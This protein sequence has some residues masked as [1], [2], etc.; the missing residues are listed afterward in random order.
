MLNKLIHTN[1]LAASAILRLALGAVFF[2]HGAQ[3]MLGWWGGHGFSATMSGFEHRGIPAA[4]A[5]LAIAAEFFGGIGLILGLLSRVAAFGIACVMLVAIFKV[6]LVNGFFMNWA[7]QQK[8][9]GFEYHVLVLA[10]TAAIMIAG[11]GAW[12]VDRALSAQL[13]GRLTGPRGSPGPALAFAESTPFDNADRPTR[14]SAAGPAPP[15]SQSFSNSR[16]RLVCTR[17][18]GISVCFLSSIRSW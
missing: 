10:M 9:E 1:P 14:A 13:V 8:G 5:F 18:T 15:H 2:A 6:H 4:L 7:G 12:S 17:L 3:K 16:S 11:S